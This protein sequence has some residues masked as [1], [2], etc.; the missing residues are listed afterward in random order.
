MDLAP[1]L[2]VTQILNTDNTFIK[3]YHITGYLY[4]VQIFTN[5]MNGLTSNENLCWAVLKFD[6][7][8]HVESKQCEEMIIGQL[9]ICHISL[10]ML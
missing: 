3:V 8:W 10:C 1:G 4:K 5:F 7:G 6:C 2:T 9:T